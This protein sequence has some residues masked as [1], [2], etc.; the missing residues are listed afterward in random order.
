MKF[1]E[2]NLDESLLRAM[3]KVGFTRP[4]PVQERAIPAALQGRDILGTAQTGTGKTVAFL[5]PSMQRLLDGKKAKN[6]RVVVL[7]PTRE[8]A[9]QVAEQARMLNLYTDLRIAAVYGGAPIKRQT[10]QL[11]RGADVIIATP[12]RLMDH[13][14]RGNA[15]FHHLEILILDEADRMLDMG[16]L[17]DIER[18]VERM[19][20]ERQTMMFSATMPQTMV[21]LSYRFM[22]DPERLEIATAHP[23]EAIRQQLFPVHKHLKLPLLIELLQGKGISSALVFTRTKQDADML[24]Q[25]LN[26][27]GMSTAVL[28][29]NFTQK[30]RLQALDQFR[31]GK[32]RILVATDVASRGLDIT[33][34]S[35]V[36]NFN[37]PEDGESYVHRIGRTAR[38]DRDGAAWTLVT[39]DDEPLISRIEYL[40]GKPIKRAYL[41][42]FDYEVP[43]PDW[44]RPSASALR[45]N[46]ER[47]QTSYDRWKA[48][49]R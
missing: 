14:Q 26:Q 29:G 4:T 34:I 24:T 45:R 21:S 48:L 17:P 19:P 40:L 31:N 44:A 42:G 28:H 10:D 2:M 3:R 33:G 30:K 15:L 12:G 11:K 25:K 37:V 23:P 13:M 49:T 27:A 5:L 1:E 38:L 47:K 20:Q 6:P 39:P 8:L 16:F 9:I 46:L 35:H 22:K 7:V 41:P 36:V 43:I 32:A 18:I